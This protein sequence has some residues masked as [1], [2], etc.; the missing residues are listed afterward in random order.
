MPV[1]RSSPVISE[2]KFPQ[3][4]PKILQIT[5]S[6]DWIDTSGCPRLCWLMCCCMILKYEVFG[7]IFFL[8]WILGPHTICKPITAITYW[9]L[10]E[11]KYTIF[12]WFMS[13]LS[14]MCLW[15]CYLLCVVWPWQRK[16]F[17]SLHIQ[18]IKTKNTF[19]TQ[20]KRC[21]RKH[22]IIHNCITSKTKPISSCTKYIHVKYIY[23]RPY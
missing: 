4:H 1:T 16:I 15:C 21:F 2:G 23:S 17:S 18:Y 12:Y 14:F 11:L 10:T 9:G 22:F 13:S 5:S 3:K 20:S 8:H 19:P 7:F 6:R